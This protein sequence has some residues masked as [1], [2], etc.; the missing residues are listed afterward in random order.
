MVVFRNCLKIYKNKITNAVK[1]FVKKPYLYKHEAPSQVVDGKNSFRV[2]NLCL[3]HFIYF[4]HKIIFIQLVLTNFC[5]AFGWLQSFQKMYLN[6]IRGISTI[7]TFKSYQELVFVL[8][9]GLQKEIFGN[10][11]NILNQYYT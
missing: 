5:I 6:N 7:Y 1:I 2:Q 10:N 3:T 4:P 8:L 11:L 9:W